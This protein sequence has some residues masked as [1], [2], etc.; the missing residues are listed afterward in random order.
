MTA[1]ES[2]LEIPFRYEYMCARVSE[3]VSVWLSADI[4]TKRYLHVNK[5]DRRDGILSVQNKNVF[6]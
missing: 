4:Q 1:D 2:T 5:K 6:Y 3:W